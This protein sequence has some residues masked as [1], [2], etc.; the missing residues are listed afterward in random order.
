MLYVDFTTR[1][2]EVTVDVTRDTISIND[3]E[4]EG[5]AP[6]R[7]TFPKKRMSVIE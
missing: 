5:Q 3:S 7:K 1:T 6:S 2:I 4:G